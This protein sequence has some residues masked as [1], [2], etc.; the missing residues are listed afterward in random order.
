MLYSSFLPYLPRTQNQVEMSESD[1]RNISSWTFSSKFR[2]FN[3]P[4]PR[5]Q[6]LIDLV[7][8]KCSSITVLFN[9]SYDFVL[10]FESQS[11]VRFA[12][13]VVVAGCVR[14]FL[15]TLNCSSTL[16]SAS[17]GRIHSPL[18]TTACLFSLHDPSGHA[19]EGH[20]QQIALENGPK[21]PYDHNTRPCGHQRTS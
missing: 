7:N 15:D 3:Y 13:I 9:P 11:R 1:N 16:R 6:T 12:V 14:P 2:N 8:S 4:T 17:R 20:R 19:S 10:F 21:K 5:P 18:P